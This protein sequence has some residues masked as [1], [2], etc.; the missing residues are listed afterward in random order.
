MT[1]WADHLGERI[2]SNLGSRIRQME[3]RN[4]VVLSR[5][6]EVV[7]FQN[8]V[9]PP[10]V[11]TT[12]FVEHTSDATMLLASEANGA[13]E[14]GLDWTQP[15]FLQR[16][17]HGRLIRIAGRMADREFHYLLNL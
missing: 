2:R 3:S 1:E 16:Q 11:T 8:N 10:I 14:L 5:F 12:S 17:I 4:S 9:N 13:A 15:D 7:S 6:P